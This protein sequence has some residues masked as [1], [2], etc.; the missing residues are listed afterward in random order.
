MGIPYYVASLVRKHKHIQTKC[1]GPVEV[2]VL[3][4]DFNCFLHRYLDPANPVG[5]LVVALD[6]L[7]TEVVRAK[8]VY[9]AFDGLVPYAK[10]VQQRYRRMRRP[11]EPSAFDKHQLS[12]GTP[13][14]REIAKTLKFL[15]PHYEVS[16]TLEPG[17]GEHKLFLWMQALPA[18][19][20]K[21]ICIYGL[22]ADLVVIAVAQSHLGD[23]RILREVEDTTDF[24]TIH[25]PSLVS[26]LP[27]D[28]ETFVTMSIMCFGNDFMPSLA[29]FSLREDGYGRAVYYANRQDADKDE[30]AIL[31]KHAKPIDRRI[32]A[33]D[34]HALEARMGCH[35][36]DGV[37]DCEPVCRAFWTTYE[38]TRLYFTTSKVPDWEWVY[39]YPE[40][41]LLSTLGAYE[42]PT[43]FVWDHPIPTRSLEDHL[44]FILPAESL[45]KA[46]L[47]PVYPDELYDEAT[48]TRTP[49]RK[50]FV[51]EA[52]PYVS[53][54]DGPLTTVSEIHPV[55]APV[56][57]SDRPEQTARPD[58]QTPKTT[59]PSRGRRGGGPQCRGIRG[60]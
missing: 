10:M 13:F 39:P 55:P 25:I 43:D 20:R 9:I 51:W 32:L 49:W 48:E 22:D 24:A 59:R 53:L 52:D 26:V 14:M 34:G 11:T 31:R 29:M 27:V 28:K 18:E 60:H 41:P 8:R 15:Y 40:A 44:R 35:L 56:P 42:R 57:V 54:P 37:L 45:R 3:G 21:T 4:I 17:E 19:E 12:P 23:I 46:G 6:R 1:K 7:L 58:G 47:E 30:L 36:M 5:S 50:R 38:W 2:D 16:D 33:P